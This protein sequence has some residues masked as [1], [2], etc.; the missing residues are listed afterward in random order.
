VEFAK[1]ILVVALE[2]ITGPQD[3]TY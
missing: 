3:T 1:I 2:V